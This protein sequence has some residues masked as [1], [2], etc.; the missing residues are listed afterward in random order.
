LKKKN[1]KKSK[2]KTP[3]SVQTYR[4]RNWKEY[5]KSLV[6]RGNLTIWISEQALAD[7]YELAR[8]G[9]R[10]SSR[11]YSKLA[12]EACLMVKM[13]FKLPLRQTE[14]F[15]NS[16]FGMM[17]IALAAPD[18]TTLSRRLSSFEVQLPLRGLGEKLHLC[19]D[20]T[21]VKVYGEGEWKVRTHGW[22]KRRTWRKLHLAIDART[23]Q[24]VSVCATSNAVDDAAK[25]EDLLSQV[26]DSIEVA[27]VSAD[28]AYDKRKT[29][30]TLN[31]HGTKAIIPPRRNAKIW[32]HGNSKKE[33][34]IRDENLRRIRKVGRK[35]WKIESGYH[36]RSL[37]ETG[38]FGYK[39]TFGGEISAR[40]EENQSN[41]MKLKCQILNLM[42]FCGMPQSEKVTI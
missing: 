22:S 24:I 7:W 28:G 16:L 37:A 17:Q 10:G 32:Q 21:G 40:K 19:I 5:N 35:G 15:V 6:N 26:P 3:K 14:G 38:V 1:T 39:Q 36:R 20:S 9:K 27:E 8:S 29:Y 18:Y 4:V 2:P 13:L 41:E 31:K 12:I 23:Q 42:T 33:R 25:V 11:T 34:H 30:N